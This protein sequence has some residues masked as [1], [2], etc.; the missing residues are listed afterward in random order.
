MF[1]KDNLKILVEKAGPSFITSL[2]GENQ[3]VEKM[4]PKVG[5]AP[6][7]QPQSKKIKSSKASKKEVVQNSTDVEICP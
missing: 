5:V 7:P 1:L 3:D 6:T 2:E 4:H